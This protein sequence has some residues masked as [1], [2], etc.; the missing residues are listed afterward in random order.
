M[1]FK[2]V[3]QAEAKAE[4]QL[5]TFRA[6]TQAQQP[7]PPKPKQEASPQSQISKSR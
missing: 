7:T 5:S 3:A 6:A 4:K 1:V 2:A